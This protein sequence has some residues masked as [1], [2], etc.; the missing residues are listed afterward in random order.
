[1]SANASGS[2]SP[3]RAAH[4]RKSLGGR[5]PLIIDGGA[6]E[7]GPESTIIA[8][9]RDMLR[10]LR[11]GPIAGDANLPAGHSIDAPCQLAS[12]SAPPPFP[13]AWKLLRNFWSLGGI[14]ARQ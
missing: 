11:P 14:I 6:T 8:A 3:T 12:H 13:R 7:R 5:I 4:V 10:P 2:I 9:T 1:P